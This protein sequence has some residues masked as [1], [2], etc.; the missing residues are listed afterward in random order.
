MRGKG[1][2]IP[3][4]KSLRAVCSRARELR[5]PL[6]PAVGLLWQ[7]LRNRQLD[8]EFRRQ[9]A[10]GRFIVDFYCHEL[11]L[12]VELDGDVHPEANQSDRDQARTEW[13]E[14]QGYRLMRFRNDEVMQNV[15]AVLEKIAAARARHALAANPCRHPPAARGEPGR[16]A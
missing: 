12:I 16:G 13:L 14:A 2:S 11:R 8:G 4:P 6:T 15:D 9:R 7:R 10:I 1:P 3:N 5:H